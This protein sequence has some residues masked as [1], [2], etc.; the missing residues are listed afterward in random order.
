MDRK[1]LDQFFRGDASPDQERQIV[2]WLE[3]NPA[4]ESYFNE[5]RRLYNT[6]LVMDETAVLSARPKKTGSFS[7]LMK[8]VARMAAVVAVAL[9]IGG[10]YYMRMARQVDSARNSITVPVGQRMDIVLSDGTKV[11]VNGASTLTYPP[12]FSGKTRRVHLT[13]EAFFDVTHDPKHPFMV[14]TAKCD[15][16]VFGTEFNVEVYQHSSE[17]TASLIE[18]KVKVYNNQNRSRDFVILGQHEQAR[19]VDN[20]LVVGQ[21]ENIENLQWRNG[22]IGFRNASFVNLMDLFEKYYGVHV[23]YN[24]NTLPQGTFSGKIRISEGI[25]HAFWVLQQNAPFKYEK[26]SDSMIITIK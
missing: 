5:E 3:Q 21:I 9:G 10:Y 18:G 20:K 14:E 22:L 7:R 6:L 11:T 19:L 4:N 16:E 23:I 24:T 12:I 13:G 2:E 1:T 25:D 17:F 8:E 15:V 26:N